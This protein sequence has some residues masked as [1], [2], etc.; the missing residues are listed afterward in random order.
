ML[1][2]CECSLSYEVL[3]TRRGHC[4]S[5][6]MTAKKTGSVLNRLF[7]LSGRQTSQLPTGT[8]AA[9]ASG[10]QRALDQKADYAFTYSHDASHFENHKLFSIKS[11]AVGGRPRRDTR[12]PLS[13]RELQWRSS[14]NLATITSIN[15]WNKLIRIL[16][17]LVASC[18]IDCQIYQRR[19]RGTITATIQ[20]T[21]W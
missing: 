7:T 1:S 13:P 11:Q 20:A 14:A 18:C 17:S 5:S 6:R 8:N 3:T 9:N 2:G 21:C 10:K 12:P 15:P 16:D 4:R 19:L